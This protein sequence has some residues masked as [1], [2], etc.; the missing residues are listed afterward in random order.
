MLRRAYFGNLEETSIEHGLSKGSANLNKTT[1]AHS[2]NVE[3]A[4]NK[5]PTQIHLSFSVHFLNFNSN[6]R[7]EI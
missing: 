3:A 2:K 4:H 5:A 6:A 7:V 1:E